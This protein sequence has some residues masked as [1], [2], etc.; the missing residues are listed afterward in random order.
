[1][2][3]RIK[4]GFHILNAGC[5]S[6]FDV[7]AEWLP[8]IEAVG[9]DISRS[10]IAIAKSLNSD[11]SFVVADIT[12]LPFK[13]DIFDGISS[14]DVLEH[15][16]EKK[17]AVTEFARVTKKGGFFIGCTTNLCHP[18]LLLDSKF[19]VLLKP[20]IARLAPGHYERHSRFS[21]Y[22][23][24]GTFKDAGYEIEKLVFSP[25]IIIEIL[26]RKYIGYLTVLFQRI[27]RRP[28][29]VFLKEMM[30]LQAT[31]QTVAQ[32]KNSFQLNLPSFN[33]AGFTHFHSWPNFKRSGPVK[34][35]TD[36]PAR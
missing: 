22:Q 12:A 10:N 3:D 1:L 27:T 8:K 11:A 9:V 17:K 24:S 29:L 30:I 26:G 2:G 23:F 33:V 15:V 7:P 28:P 34:K 31:K 6:C 5:G 16:E 13:Q 20:F 25:S 19:P 21:P 36:P 18:V 35:D 32:P 4:S 14:I